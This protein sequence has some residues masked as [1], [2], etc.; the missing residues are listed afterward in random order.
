MMLWLNAF[1]LLSI[2]VLKLHC[3]QQVELLGQVNLITEA[4]LKL[5]QQIGKDTTLLLSVLFK[6]NR[7]DWIF[8]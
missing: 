2:V 3:L 1:I 8:G 4:F 7:L 6:T 5:I